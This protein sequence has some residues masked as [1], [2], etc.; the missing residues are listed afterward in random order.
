MTFRNTLAVLLTSAALTMGFAGCGD[1]KEDNTNQ[2][3]TQDPITDPKPDDPSVEPCKGDECSAKQQDA[4]NKMASC[5][6]AQAYE[7]I[8]AIYAAQVKDNKLDAQTA[9]DRSILGLIHILYRED[10]Q[11]IL[12]KLGF[13]AKS[14]LVDFKPL[15]QADNGIFKQVFTGNHNYDGYGDLIPMTI[16]KDDDKAWEDT[17]DKSLTFDNVLDVLVN[18]KPDLESLASSLEEAAKLTGA[19]PLSPNAKIGCGLNNFKMDAADLNTFAALLMAADAAIDLLAH[20]DFDFNIHDTIADS[21]EA[22]GSAEWISCAVVIDNDD[23]VIEDEC[24]SYHGLNYKD[25]ECNEAPADFEDRTVYYCENTTG[26]RKT[27]VIV[28]DDKGNPTDDEC[29]TEFSLDYKTLFCGEHSDDDEPYLECIVPGDTDDEKKLEKYASMLL[30][31]LFKATQSKRQVAGT[32]GVSAFKKAA[33]LYLQALDG[34]AKGAFFDFSKIPA[35]ALQ[36]MKD[37]AKEMADGTGSLAKFIKPGLTVD[38]NKVFKD[39]LFAADNE[40]QKDP[41]ANNDIETYGDDWIGDFISSIYGDEVFLNE[42][43]PNYILNTDLIS[44]EIYYSDGI[45]YIELDFHANNKYDAT[46]S[47]AWEDLNLGHWL[48]PHYYFAPQC[49]EGEECPEL[50][51]DETPYYY[52]DSNSSEG[53]VCTACWEKCEGKT[54]YCVS[55]IITGLAYCID[56]PECPKGEQPY[57]G[58]SPIDDEF[59]NDATC[60]SMD[61]Y[62]SY[63][64]CADDNWQ[65]PDGRYVHYDK[66]KDAYTCSHCQDA[67]TGDTPYC[68][69]RYPGEDYYSAY[70]C[71][72]TESCPDG[73]E[74]AMNG[75]CLPKSGSPCPDELK[76]KDICITQEMGDYSE[77]A[78]YYCDRY[79]EVSISERSDAE[80][81]EVDVSKYGTDRKTIAVLAEPMSPVC[82]EN[83][84]YLDC[85]N[86]PDNKTAITGEVCAKTTDNTMVSINLINRGIYIQVCNENQYCG[87]SNELNMYAC[88]NMDEPEPEPEPEY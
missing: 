57:E 16:A 40:F 76:T 83:D 26:Q 15:W 80:C 42:K 64:F 41:T 6:F 79:G 58:P 87:Y 31:H 34:S 45:R 62:E 43:L 25:L 28:L 85:V 68:V 19:T 51:S 21:P 73:F 3:T 46:F 13:I 50:C 39:V 33:A 47:S 65:A 8:N 1:D 30:P 29:K 2:P 22:H 69:S 17:I 67:C 10:V 20:Y 59:I 24:K 27:C 60:V 37:I 49:I 55:N 53:Y 63:H 81:K 35:G 7:D 84:F 23:N 18:L 66:T 72:A 11:A 74:F 61:G 56:K 75:Q 86:T 4:E 44:H 54:P 48:N 12:P 5:D 14:G 9:L 38:L 88:L 77:A 70:F 32:D 82:S 71:A 52:K 78:L 36:D